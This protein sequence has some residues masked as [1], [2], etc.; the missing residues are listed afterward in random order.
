MENQ[1][2]SNNKGI[3]IA[4]V[5]SILLVISLGGYIVYDKFLSDNPSTENN[6]I[7]NGNNNNG[8]NINN[9]DN[10]N[11]NIPSDK[12]VIADFGSC[13]T[14]NTKNTCTTTASVNNKTVSL[15]L[16]KSTPAPHTNELY[17]D[18]VNIF[19]DSDYVFLEDLYNKILLH[20]DFIVVAASGG[21][22]PMLGF[23]YDYS[24]KAL[25]NRFETSDAI[26][27]TGKKISDYPEIVSFYNEFID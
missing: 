27:T 6:N 7:N 15:K 26:S 25:L 9:N 14:D 5:I 11:D 18:N 24:G 8:N 22:A 17:V 2:K 12:I 21:G 13:A 4:L 1:I 19:A 16:N 23:V 10:D 20:K 3:V